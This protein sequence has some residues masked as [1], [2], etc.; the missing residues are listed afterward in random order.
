MSPAVPCAGQQVTESAAGEQTVATNGERRSAAEEDQPRDDTQEP[1]LK[2]WIARRIDAFNSPSPRG[3]N[4]FSFFGGIIV[5]GSGLAAGVG[6]HQQNVIKD[7]IDYQVQG[8]FSIHRYQQ[9][10]AAIGLL[11]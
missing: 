8:A 5:A 6:Y 9:Y 4:H 2:G 1:G 3:D 11:D 7:R 10:R